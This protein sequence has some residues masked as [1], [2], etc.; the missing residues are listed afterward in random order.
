VT[1]RRFLLLLVLAPLHWACATPY[2]G[3]LAILMQDHHLSPAVWGRAFVVAMAS[4]IAALFLFGRLRRRFGLPALLA[5]AFAATAVRWVLVGVVRGPAALVLLQLVHFCTFGLYWGAALGWL[6]ACVPPRLR[7]TGQTLFTAATYG[8]GTISGMF[9]SGAIYDATG[10]A[11]GAFVTAGV[12]ELL[13][14]ALVLALGRRLD[15][16]AD[17]GR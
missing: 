8:L 15:P 3:F 7:A 16:S 12:V 11:E 10:G 1:D 2:H 6:G 14:L 4:E 5:A 13:P 17:S 9:A